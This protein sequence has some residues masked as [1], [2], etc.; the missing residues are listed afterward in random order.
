MKAF[1][2]YLPAREHSVQ[3]SAYMLETLKSYGLDAYLH[4]GVPG[5][6]AVKLAAKSKKT[7]YPY[8]IK[9]RII[10][11]ADLK[12]LIRP[13]LYED[14]KKRYHYNIVER[15]PIGEDHIGKLSRP[16]VVGCFYSHYALWEKCV[17]LNEPIMIFEDD[18]K[19]YRGWNPIEFNG[20][21]ILSL[22]KSSF[23]SE[24]NKTYLENPTGIP[25]PMPWRNFSM[26]GASGYA[27]TPDA[28]LGLIK[29]Y[30]PYWY[31]ADNA[32]NQF[33]TPMYIHN[34]IM[35]RN[36]LPEE[37]NVSMT[38]SKDWSRAM[39]TDIVDNDYKE[40]VITAST[41]PDSEIDQ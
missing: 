33:I 1:I 17:E 29:F 19:F 34:Y 14:F 21:L 27:L 36:T 39:E 11:D 18:V 28:A 38:K 9:N 22:G 24:P 15:Q 3:H 20:V 35:G 37:G 41:D 23:L 40:L 8:S 13:K 16:G 2:I 12:R 4:E 5:D 6:V 31:P 7:L 25:R 30:K 32:I 10:D 26:P